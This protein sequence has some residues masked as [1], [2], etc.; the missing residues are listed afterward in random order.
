LAPPD[1]SIIVCRP[2]ENAMMI[3]IIM[4][5]KEKGRFRCLRFNK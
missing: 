2:D 1:D 4:A 5:R 3:A